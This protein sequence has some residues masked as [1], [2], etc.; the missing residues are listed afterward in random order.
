MPKG[1]QVIN[2]REYVYEYRSV[3]NKDKKRSEQKRVYLGRIINNEFVPNTQYRLREEV[4]NTL[5]ATG[6]RHT[7][8]ATQCK[9]QFVG[10]TYLFDQIGKKIGVYDDIK[11]SFP[12]IHK[13]ILSLAYYLALESCSPMYRFKHWAATH[14][15]PCERDIP[16][17]RISDLLPMITEAQKMDFLKRQ[18]QRRTEKEYLFFDSTS[19]SSYSE[20]LKQVKYGKNKDG[21][22]L[23]QINLALLF[24]QV[25][26]LPAFYRKLSDN[27]NDVITI[28]HL[29]KSVK[30]LDIKKICFIL[31]RGYYSAK[32]INAM[33]KEHHKFVIG[34]KISLNI[35]QNIIEEERINFDCIDNYNAECELFIKTQTIDWE[36]REKKPRSGKIIKDKRR[37]YVHIY[38]NDQ[39]ATD[40]RKSLYKMLNKLEDDLL[41]GNRQDGKAKLYAKYYDIKETPIRGIRLTPKQGAIDE[42]RKN[43]GFFALLANEIKDPVEALKMYRSKDMIEKSF[44]DLKDRLSMRRTQVSSEENLEGKLFLQFVGLIYLSY[45][46]QVM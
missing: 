30:Y 43:L 7:A 34:A 17:Q 6:K 39:L 19:I 27:I 4:A 36:Y 37:M 46:K 45:V 14:A 12:G 11:A 3:W 38:Y 8:P 16:S 23:P 44:A 13:E 28:I 33:F 20:Q 5:T 22:S 24:G 31:D 2:G 1:H 25:S 10:A 35:V 32:N 9:R 15:H 26:R 21:D 18:S 41:T 40:E 42:A 29:L